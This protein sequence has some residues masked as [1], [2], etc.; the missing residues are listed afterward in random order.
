MAGRGTDI[1]LQEEVKAAGGLHVILTEINDS[2]R[3]D[4]Q[5]IGRCARQGDP[6]SYRIFLSDADMLM[7]E[8]NKTQLWARLAAWFPLFPREFFFRGAQSQIDGKKIRDR[9]AM[10]YHEKKRLR[11]LKQSGLDPVLDIVD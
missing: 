7:D 6:G 3:I 2:R 10:L 9:L 8:K 4:R 5:L 11:L 1:K